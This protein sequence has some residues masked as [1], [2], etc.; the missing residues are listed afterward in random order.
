MSVLIL[1]K[2]RFKSEKRMVPSQESFLVGYSGQNIYKIYFPETGKIEHLKDVIFIKNDKSLE[3]S[4]PEDRDLF[5]YPDFNSKNTPVTTNENISQ[6]I[7]LPVKLSDTENG[8]SPIHSNIK[9]L[10][11][12]STR[13]QQKLPQYNTITRHLAMSSVVRKVIY[14]PFIYN[15]AL[16]ASKAM[17]WQKAMQEQYNIFIKNHTWDIV[18]IPKD[19]KILKEK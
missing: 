9:T 10:P 8:L 14:K 15:K 3:T 1:Q 12:H 7:E 13:T 2:K 17:Q 16:H 4:L 5:Y 6:F 19:Q 11:R 18:Y